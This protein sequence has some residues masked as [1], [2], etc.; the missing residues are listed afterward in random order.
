MKI[1]I[2][3]HIFE[4]SSNWSYDYLFM[5]FTGI[6]FCCHYLIGWSLLQMPQL[7]YDS[8]MFIILPEK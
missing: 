5:H 7:E 6:V 2:G 3:R 8:T 4:T 1:Q